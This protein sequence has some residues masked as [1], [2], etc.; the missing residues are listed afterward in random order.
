M[1]GTLHRTKEGWFVRYNVF[2]EP[3]DRE[4]EVSEISLT[5]PDLSTYWVEGREVNF[6][7]NFLPRMDTTEDVFI[8]PDEETW[9]DIFKNICDQDLTN[10]NDIWN[11]LKENYETP[12]R[13]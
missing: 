11:W 6:I 13:K 7:K 8:I 12:K 9:D 4:L 1:T 10:L 3:Y 5:N 2:N